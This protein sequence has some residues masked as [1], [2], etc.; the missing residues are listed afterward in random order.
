MPG[1]DWERATREDYVLTLVVGS[2]EQ[3]GT[4]LPLGGGVFIPLGIAQRVAA[5]LNTIIAP[6]ITYGYYSQPRS[7]GQTFIG[8]TSISDSTLLGLM[9]DIMAEFLGH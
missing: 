7:G 5:R 8:T 3:H 4:H 9:N 6:P 2:I 1:Q